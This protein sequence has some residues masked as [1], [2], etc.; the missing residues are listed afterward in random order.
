[1]RREIEMYKEER[2]ILGSE[3]DLYSRKNRDD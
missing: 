3:N 2:V 1:M